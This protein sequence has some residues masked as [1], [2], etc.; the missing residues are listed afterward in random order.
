MYN[1]LWMLL[2]LTSGMVNMIIQVNTETALTQLFHYKHALNR[3]VHA[4]SMQLDLS[5]L[6]SGRNIIHSDRAQAAFDEVLVANLSPAGSSVVIQ[7]LEFVVVNGPTFP[8]S[9]ISRDGSFRINVNRP[10]VIVVL[11]LVRPSLTALQEEQ[12]WHVQA[13]SELVY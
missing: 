7:K 8:S 13:V 10:A 2:I 9:F 12:Q 3:A 1:L 11:H 5:S 4:A 6:A